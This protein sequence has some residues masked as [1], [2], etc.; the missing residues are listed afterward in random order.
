[1]T[2]GDR[3]QIVRLT[4]AALAAVFS[5]A[6]CS[7]TGLQPVTLDGAKASNP[8][9]SGPSSGSST[10]DTGFSPFG[11]V[12]ATSGIAGGREVMKNPKVADIMKPVSTLSEMSLGRPDAPVTMIKYASMTCPY[13]RRFDLEVFPEIKRRYIDTGKMRFIIRE[14]PIGFQS[15][16]ATV[17][18]RCASPDKYFQLYHKLMAQQ[19]SWVSQEVRPEPIFKVAAQVG[20]T[21]S[22]FDACRKNQKLIDGLKAIKDRGRTLGV[23][24][25]PNFFINGRLIKTVLT[26]QDVKD[27]VDPILSGG[28]AALARRT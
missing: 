3:S 8:L 14:F 25:T 27:I 19:A 20:L 22:Q 16:L 10:L 17:A 21:R 4:T 15:G 12:A 6:G 2:Y 5:L 1:M 9:A 13:C 11:D 7:T 23:I 18:L 24:G 28:G 26:L